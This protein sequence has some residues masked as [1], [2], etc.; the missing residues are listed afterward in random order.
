MDQWKRALFHIFLIRLSANSLHKINHIGRVIVS[1]LAASVVDLKFELRSGENLY[2]LF[3]REA[4]SIK[5]NEQ[6]LVDRE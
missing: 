6:I 5:N 4:L 3:P 2:L 1:V